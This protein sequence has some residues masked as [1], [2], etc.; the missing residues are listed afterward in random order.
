MNKYNITNYHNTHKRRIKSLSQ[1]IRDVYV[2]FCIMLSLMILVLCPNHSY[3]C[4][5]SNNLLNS[6]IRN[7]LAEVL[8]VIYD[9]KPSIVIRLV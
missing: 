4:S 3:R 2:I 6:A 5:L 8:L 1:P 7:C 9:L